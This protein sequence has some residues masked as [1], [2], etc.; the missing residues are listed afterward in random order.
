MTYPPHLQLRLAKYLEMSEE[1][2]YSLDCE[3]RE[4]L[5]TQK[6]LYG[7]LRPDLYDR[8]VPPFDD[9][10][11]KALVESPFKSNPLKYLK[12][13]GLK[14]GLNVRNRL[15]ARWTSFHHSA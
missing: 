8:V 14:V 9:E 3:I 4:E 12:N 11:A 1:E 7:R 2:R 6:Q 13:L 15:L 10:T 5:R